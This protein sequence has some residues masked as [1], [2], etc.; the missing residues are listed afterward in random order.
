MKMSEGVCC[1]K[2]LTQHSRR[3]S[4]L[5]SASLPFLDNLVTPWST[6]FVVPCPFDSFH[7][8]RTLRWATW[9]KC[10]GYSGKC[11]V[12]KWGG[13]RSTA[14]HRET[15]ST[16]MSLGRG[17]CLGRGRR[18]GVSNNSRYFAIQFRTFLLHGCKD[19]S[20]SRLDKPKAVCLLGVYTEHMLRKI[21]RHQVWVDTPFCFV[22]F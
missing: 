3:R 21:L 6:L 11:V 8:F 2:C 4:D 19:N 5:S 14:K 16:G 15:R 17:G 10:R 22:A 13:S 12:R 1:R 9:S 7:P 20:V 18:W